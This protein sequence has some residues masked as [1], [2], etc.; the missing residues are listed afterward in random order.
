MLGGIQGN[1]LDESPQPIRPM[2]ARSHPIGE[3][4]R[5]FSLR[6][7]GCLLVTA[8]KMLGGGIFKFVYKILQPIRGSDREFGPDE[9]FGITVVGFEVSADSV[10]KFA[11]AVVHR[12]A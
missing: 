3:R 1:G 11:G 9:G 2:K 6:G 12:A 10:L 8:R 7:A 4:I 5:P